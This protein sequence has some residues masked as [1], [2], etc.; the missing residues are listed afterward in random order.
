MDF[1]SMHVKIINFWSLINNYACSFNEGAYSVFRSHLIGSLTMAC[2]SSHLWNSYWLHH[3]L[4]TVRAIHYKICW[5]TY[6]TEF[7]RTIIN[8]NQNKHSTYIKNAESTLIDTLGSLVW[9]LVGLESPKSFPS[10][11]LCQVSLH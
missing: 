5:H 6:T 1:C 10:F 8:I 11:T 7:K 2:S 9:K 4:K 3:I